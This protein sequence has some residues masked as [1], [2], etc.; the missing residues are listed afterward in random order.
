MYKVLFI[1]IQLIHRQ[2]H[3]YTKHENKILEGEAIKQYV[4]IQFDHAIISE[5]IMK[6]IQQ[7]SM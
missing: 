2:P 6:K 3:Q 4:S 5:I 7:H 1:Y